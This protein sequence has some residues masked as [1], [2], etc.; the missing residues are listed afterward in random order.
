MPAQRGKANMSDDRR[1]PVAPADGDESAVRAID[2]A[3]RQGVIRGRERRL[4]RNKRRKQ[5]AASGAMVLL[6]LLTGMLTIRVSPAFASMMRDIPGMK[7]FVDMIGRGGDTG[8]KL[9]MKSELVQ[10][11][12]RSDEADG[13]KLTI[14]GVLA[15]EQRAVLFYELESNRPNEPLLRLNDLKLSNSDGSSLQA[16]IM[17]NMPDEYKQ[18]GYASG[19]MR[20][21][22]DLQLTAET[23]I[24]DM[25][26]LH[27]FANAAPYDETQKGRIKQGLGPLFE[28]HGRAIGPFDIAIPIQ[29]SKIA[30]FTHVV[31]LNTDVLADGQRISFT[32]ATVSPLRVSVRLAYAKSNA[33]QVTGPGDIRLVDE[34][35]TVWPYKGGFGQDQI[36]FESPYFKQPKKL[37][38]E[39]SW[40]RA[41]DKD[42]DALVIDTEAKKLV[43]GPD[44]N[45]KLASV[46]RAGNRI[47][48]ALTLRKTKPEDNVVYSLLVKDRFKD[49]AGTVYTSVDSHGASFQ[50]AEPDKQTISFTIAA[51]AYEQPLVF[52]LS[53]YPNYVAQPYRIELPLP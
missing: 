6:L 14:Q 15:D 10:S 5:A 34:E 13:I 12:G 39:G 38:L 28:E 23:K 48:I 53:D 29:K 11:V 30:E 8:L 37:F 25:I 22:I 19:K 7:V 4:L 17:Y 20:G 1:P 46:T 32:E 21:Y 50:A 2:F 3:I 47:E 43:R 31:S 16:A 18:K 33:K 49:S 36:Y 40:F 27:A 44:A 42:K 41:F 45:V 26:I 35:G 24:Q 51:E 9:A 52:R